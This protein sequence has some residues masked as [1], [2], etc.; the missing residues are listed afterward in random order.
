MP[1]SRCS[2]G[3]LVALVLEQQVVALAL[4]ERLD[5]PGEH[6]PACRA[7]R[8]CNGPRV[9][10]T[11]ISRLD[12]LAH[13]A[14]VEME[15]VARPSATSTSAAP[16]G[17]CPASWSILPAIR[18][19]ASSRP[20]LC[21]KSTLI[22]RCIAPRCGRARC[23]SMAARVLMR[24][25]MRLPAPAA[26]CSPRPARAQAVQSGGRLCHRRAGRAR[27]SR[28]GHVR[29][30]SLD[31]RPRVQRLS[32]RQRRRR[33][34]ADLAI[35]AHR[36]RLAALQQPAVR[37]AADHRLA[38]YRR[39]AAL[40]RRLHRAG[41]RPGRA[42]LGLSQPLSQRLRR[43]ARR[44]STHL[45]AGAV[46][47]VPLRPITREALMLALCRIQLDKGSWNSIGLGFYKGLRFHIDSKKAR[48]WGTAGPR[49]GYGCPAVLA[50]RR[51]CR[52]ARRRRSRHRRTARARSA[53]AGR[54]DENPCVVRLTHHI[55]G[56]RGVRPWIS[57]N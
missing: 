8:T 55:L 10:S 53:R 27:L 56:N 39:R 20:S 18:R 42:G 48:E 3:S 5:R 46:D 2:R 57:R 43:A 54:S 30:L 9:S 35:A 47:M 52:I 51:H 38:Q 7:A 26:C 23:F 13:R 21:G 41:D 28:L 14:D 19:R 25:M 6:A 37:G 44:T 17:I 45:T 4:Q 34:R 1:D 40:H 50:E 22:G 36:D 32:H 31:L 33:G 49:G 16:P 29:A 11:A 15:R 24:A 12:R